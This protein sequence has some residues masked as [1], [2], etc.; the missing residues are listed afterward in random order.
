[1]TEN[2]LEY[3]SA[4]ARCALDLGKSD[5]RSLLVQCIK[6]LQPTQDVDKLREL[7][8]RAMSEV[9]DRPV[10][11]SRLS[12]NVIKLTRTGRQAVGRAANAGPMRL[13][14]E[15]RVGRG[16]LAEISRDQLLRCMLQSAPACDLELEH[17]L[18]A[19]RYVLL[20]AAMAA[21]V[22]DVASEPVLGLC[23][24][25][26]QQCFINEY[27]LV[28]SVDEQRRPSHLRPSLLAP[29]P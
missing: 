11:L 2:K 1:F 16:G 12:A 13:S 20:E 5:A 15:E 22:S 9:W 29:L 10:E 14:E 18:S 27:V 4:A 6:D 23:S 3:A 19:L 28:A 17:L 21:A 8:I 24:A 25:L 7:I 26:A